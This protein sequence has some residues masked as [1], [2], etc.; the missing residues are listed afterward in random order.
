MSTLTTT[1]RTVGWM[2]MGVI[3]LV[4]SLAIGGVAW[5]LFAEPQTMGNYL[6]FSLISG[7]VLG[8]SFLHHLLKRFFTS[9]PF[10][11]IGIH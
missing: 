7:V 9:C 10:C 11:W 8:L 2:M 4:C 6:L 3:F 5:L 1:Q